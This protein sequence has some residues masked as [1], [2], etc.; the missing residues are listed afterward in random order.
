MNK[1]GIVG[2]GGVARYAQLPAYRERKL[3]VHAI[4]DVNREIL[5]AVGDQFGIANRYTSV[6]EMIRSGEIDILDIATPP[7]THMDLLRAVCRSNLAVVMQKPFL[8]TPE[9]LNEAKTLV[10]AC[11]R[12][13]LNLTGRYVSA[14]KKV[15]D[16]LDAKHIGK[17]LLCTIIN[18]DWWDREA[19]RWDTTVKDYIIYEM[20]IHHLD[21][22]VFWYGKPKAVTA[23]GGFNE[24]QTM[25]MMNWVTVM[26]EY[27]NGFVVQLVENW[28]MS[29]YTFASGHPF[30]EILITGTEGSIKATSESVQA[31]RTHDNVINSWS[32]PRPG[33][34]L[35]YEM[36]TDNWF[37]GS[38]GAAMEDYMK[39]FSD[40]NYTAEDKAYAT[41]LTELTFK[42][43]QASRSEHWVNI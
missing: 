24:Q 32:L 35:P 30:E 43:A 11:A 28:A 7:H 27:E 29:E 21:L 2:V 23:R 3:P 41:W 12:F 26:L 18:Q 1:I 10:D 15:K 31:S 22:C 36:L 6:D 38:F 5:H 9:D 19:S 20:L 33:Q 8:V 40:E 39:R 14:W 13:K 25:K 16:L 37:F 4:C 17:P 42:V 34:I